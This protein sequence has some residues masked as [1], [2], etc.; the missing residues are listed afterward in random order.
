MVGGEIT[1]VIGRVGTGEGGL[2]IAILLTVASA[3][4][5]VQVESWKEKTRVEWRRRLL[6]CALR[7][8]VQGAGR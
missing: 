5:G 1:I 4:V 7:Q 2:G 8:G 6:S 3:M